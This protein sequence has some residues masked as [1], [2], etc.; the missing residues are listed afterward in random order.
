MIESP[1]IQ[2]LM[3]DRTQTTILRFLTGRFGPVPPE[4]VTALQAVV[5]ANRLDA[6]AE[7]AGRCPDLEAFRAQ[8]SP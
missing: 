4:I 2:E 3:A 7:W 6:L 8:L 5:D 1:L